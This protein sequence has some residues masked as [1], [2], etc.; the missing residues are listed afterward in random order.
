M[1]SS[2]ITVYWSIDTNQDIQ[3]NNLFSEL[4]KQRNQE[5]LYEGTFFSCPAISN[6]FKNTF[7]FRSNHNF[8]YSYSHFFPKMNIVLDGPEYPTPQVDHSAALSFGPQIRKKDTYLFFTEEESLLATFTAPYFHQSKY[9]N[10]GSVFPGSFDIGSWFRQYTCEFQMWQNIGKFKIEHG[11][12]LFYVNF[13]TDKKIILKEFKNTS[14]I[15]E[16]AIYCMDSIHR[17]GKRLSLNLI[18]KEIK[19]NLVIHN[20]LEIK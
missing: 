3:P 9:Q 2:A 11:E 8:Q 16:Y 4:I 5:N 13:N 14:K 7:V 1:S 18:L 12:P 19:N 10:Y 15:T 20:E 6:L 17:D